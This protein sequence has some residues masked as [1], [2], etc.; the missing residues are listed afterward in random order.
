MAG[1]YIT[2]HVLQ[3]SVGLVAE[4]VAHHKAKKSQQDELEEVLS[5]TDDVVEDTRY[6]S[7]ETTPSSS[8]QKNVPSTRY[9]EE[10]PPYD[11]AVSQGE[12]SDTIESEA[13]LQGATA[14][15]KEM[16][17]T[18][19]LSSFVI[20]TGNALGPAPIKT[21]VSAFTSEYPPVPSGSALQTTA[22]LPQ[23]RPGDL[24]RG[25]LRAYAPVLQG[26]GIS[27]IAWID[28]L[29]SFDESLKVP[30]LRCALY[31]TTLI[32]ARFHQLSTSSILLLVL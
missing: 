8:K 21:I 32:Q 28:F 18:Q 31:F 1:Y 10:P 14:A 30:A 16:Q 19:T 20:P 9:S 25:F 11:E 27:S 3:P 4:A 5:P 24:S 17:L 29:A 22:V 15:F 7:L 13:Q 6:S 23:K 26:V 12:K 2:R